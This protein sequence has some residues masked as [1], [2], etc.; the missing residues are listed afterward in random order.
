[1][2][3]S[4]AVILLP[5]SRGGGGGAGKREEKEDGGAYPLLASILRDR[6]PTSELQTCSRTRAGGGTGSVAREAGTRDAM[7]ER[8]KEKERKGERKRG[9][10]REMREQLVE[11]EKLVD[12]YRRRSRPSS[13][14]SPHALS[15]FPVR[16]F[17]PFPIKNH[18]RDAALSRLRALARE[19]RSAD[20]SKQR[21]R[22][23]SRSCSLEAPPASSNGQPKK[24]R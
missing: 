19:Q 18:A 13:I 11:F 14:S 21:A 12:F 9:K 15:I 1:M 16:S 20:L 22:S 24:S 10:E 17:L 6:R 4:S 5:T 2:T 3:T 8:E 23:A 7:V